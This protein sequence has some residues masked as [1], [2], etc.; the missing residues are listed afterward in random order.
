MESRVGV[1]FVGAGIVAE[2]HGRGVTAS[3]SARFVGV[4]DPDAGKAAALASRFGGRNY[5]SLGELLADREVRGVH[6]LTS[7]EHH[8]STA[9]AA[10]RAGKDVLVEKPVAASQEEIRTLK[11]VARE[12]GRICMPAHNYIYVPSLRRARRLIESGKLGQIASLWVLYNI[13]HAEEI[14]SIY[15]GVLRAVCTHHAYSLLYL[16][17]RPK[18][19]SCITSR[20]HY[21]RLTC[22]DQAMIT[23]EMENGAIANLWCSFAAS[24]PT[25]DPWTVIYKVLGTNGGLNYSWNEAQFQDDGGPAWGLPCYEEGFIEEID[26]FVNECIL[27][28]KAP[29]STLDDAADALAMLEAAERAAGNPSSAEF[30]VYEN[31][32]P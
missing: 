12:Q 17:G 22:E 26:F 31:S 21:E 14:A 20:V 16:L 7:L 5:A 4:Y 6:V 19:V 10:M 23:C 30:A 27:G 1:A 18:R 13:F 11:K 15:G 24:D 8:V 32:N 2:M 28:G 3:T 29:L 25:N 9:I